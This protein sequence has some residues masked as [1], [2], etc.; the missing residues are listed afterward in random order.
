[1]PPY[2]HNNDQ[3]LEERSR[4]ASFG[5]PALDI[6]Y[7]VFQ[8]RPKE[9]GAFV[10]GMVDVMQHPTQIAAALIGWQFAFGQRRVVGDQGEIRGEFPRPQT[11]AVKTLAGCRP[12]FSRAAISA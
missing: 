4:H 2:V 3:A 8:P 7:A 6:E 12:A 10:P 5:Q 11:R 9:T 1:M